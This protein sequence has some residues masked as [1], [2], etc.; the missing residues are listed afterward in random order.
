M[1]YYHSS[2][3]EREL[4]NSCAFADLVSDIFSEMRPALTTLAT[5]T[6]PET[7]SN[8]ETVEFIIEKPVMI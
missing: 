3:K 5:N 6:I 7:K 2:A 8:R 4:N 1:E